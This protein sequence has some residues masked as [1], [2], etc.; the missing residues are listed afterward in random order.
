M[1]FN[2]PNTPVIGDVVAVGNIKRKRS[3]KGWSIVTGAVVSSTTQSDNGIIDLS[4]GSYHKIFIDGGN[5][6]ISFSGISAGSSK[7]AVE[8]EIGVS[9]TIAW[10]AWVLAGAASKPPVE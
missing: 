9:S 4:S 3:A 8:L 1:A 7:W 5:V 10:F 2:F 6:A